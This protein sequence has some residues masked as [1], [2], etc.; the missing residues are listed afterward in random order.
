MPLK[1]YGVYLD[2]ELDKQLIDFLAPYVSRSRVGSVIRDALYHY[3]NKQP[4][5]QPIVKPQTV[6]VEEPVNTGDIKKVIK[7]QF[8]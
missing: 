4:M 5:Q 6:K 1:H 3:I 7:S 8:K 2:D